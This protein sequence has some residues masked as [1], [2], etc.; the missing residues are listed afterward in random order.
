[1]TTTTFDRAVE[2]VHLAE[3]DPARSASAAVVLARQARRAGDFATAS[4]A[5]RALGIAALHLQDTDVAAR[6]LRTA[7]A[8][9]RRAADPALVVEA[10]L[11]LVAVLTNRGRPAAALREMDA[12]LAEASG[13]DHARAL[14]Q[15]GAMLVQ[16]GMNDAASDTLSLAIPPL[17][18]ADDLQWLKRALSNRGL[19]RGRRFRFD[20]AEADL[21]EALRINVELGIDLSVAFVE[22]NLG[23]ISSLRGEVPRA[24]AHF[25]R[26]EETLR[27]LNAQIGFLLQDRAELLFSV[28]LVAE[29]REVAEEA[30]AALEAERQRIALPEVRLL[31]ARLAVLDADPDG[32][33]VQASRAVRELGRQRRPEWGVLA[34]FVVTA[35]RA[36]G[37]GRSRILVRSLLTAADRLTEAGWPDAAVEA[38][39]LAA[40]LAAE[41]APSAPGP[42]GTAAAGA[43]HAT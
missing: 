7:A 15:K 36:A 39:L 6:H 20:D 18:A 24:L 1:M 37:A 28:G 22:Q 32:G 2:A 17:R 42:D 30:V 19:A 23:W 35:C 16:L 5:Y 12:V 3:V 8:L 4:V 34:R 40:H 14:A 43:G 9:G 10:R 26:A 13:V 41:R 21:R 38:R 27:K 11:K 33:L 25:D 29:A 31:L